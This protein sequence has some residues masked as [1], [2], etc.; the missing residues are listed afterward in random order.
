M[1][2]CCVSQ[3]VTKLDLIRQAFACKDVILQL[4]HNLVPICTKQ[5]SVYAML[6]LMTKLTSIRH[7]FSLVIPR[8]LFFTEIHYSK[9]EV[10]HTCL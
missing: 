9:G 8:F 5:N 2:L 7:V 3:T 10:I 4:L 6:M 1:Q